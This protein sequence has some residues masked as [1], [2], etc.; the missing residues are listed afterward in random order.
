M[1]RLSNYIKDIKDIKETILSEKLIINQRFDE[2]LIINKNYK[3]NNKLDD[4]VS[5]IINDNKIKECVHDTESNFDSQE[6]LINI[7]AE[8]SMVASSGINSMKGYLKKYLSKWWANKNMFDVANTCTK[9]LSWNHSSTLINPSIY[10][11]AGEIENYVNVATDYDEL[12]ITA[13]G[14]FNVMIEA[15]QTEDYISF[16]M[17]SS[18][19]K[20]FIFLGMLI[21]KL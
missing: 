17:T 3:N 11:L 15:Y 7:L 1:K 2:K 4:I 6:E 18:K 16:I 12:H 10:K 5:K 9:Y 19:T 8:I 20:K 14:N 21:C 13:V